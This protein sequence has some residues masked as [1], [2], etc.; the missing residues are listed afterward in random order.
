MLIYGFIQNYIYE[1]LSRIS[2]WAFNFFFISLLC[3]FALLCYV[4]RSSFKIW[5][6]HIIWSSELVF[7]LTIC[8]N[9]GVNPNVARLEIFVDYFSWG[10]DRNF[11]FEKLWSI[12]RKWIRNNPSKRTTTY[13]LVIKIGS[14]SCNSSERKCGWNITLSN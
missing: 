13:N 14:V 5:S 1:N 9:W 4:F 7:K 3:S 11:L 8:V 12:S 10:G 6:R 2:R